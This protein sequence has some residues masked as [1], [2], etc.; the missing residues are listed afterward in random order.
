[1]TTAV[2]DLESGV[3]DGNATVRYFGILTPLAEADT[4]G[5]TIEADIALHAVPAGGQSLYEA[6]KALAILVRA[7]GYNV[8]VSKNDDFD[9]CLNVRAGTAGVSVTAATPVYVVA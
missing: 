5:I 4:I 3:T 8:S 1:M 2:L 6:L 7:D 9:Q